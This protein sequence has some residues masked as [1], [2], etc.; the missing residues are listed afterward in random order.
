MPE[1]QLEALKPQEVS[2]LFAYLKK[3]K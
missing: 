2:D 3:L 1:G